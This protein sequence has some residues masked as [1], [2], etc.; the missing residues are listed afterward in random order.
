MGSD[1]PLNKMSIEKWNASVQF[2]TNSDY[3]C[4]VIGADFT[5]SSKGNPMLVLEFEV[6]KPEVV[7]IGEK[8]FNIAGVTCKS[9]FTTEVTNQGEDNVAK[10]ESCRNRLTGEE[11][12]FTVM[13]IDKSTIDWDN[14][15]T[16]PFLGK[17]VYCLMEPDIEERRKNPTPEQIAKAKAAN[18]RAEGDVMVNPITGKPLVNYWPK[19]R[20][21]FGLAPSDGMQ[22][23]F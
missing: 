15:D 1:L 14:I 3:I 5:P 9:Y 20:Q 8:Q 16:K 18:K 13:G 22:V 2:P 11:G 6:V 12:L 7:D 17:L 10:T 4:R 23:A 19:I 21:I